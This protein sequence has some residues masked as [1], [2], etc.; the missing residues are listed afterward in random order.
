MNVF[1]YGT[2]LV[3]KIWN[4]VTRCPDLISTPGELAGFSV[5]KVRHGE[6]PGIVES[7]DSA[8]K[9]PGKVFFDVPEIALRRLDAYE[10]AYYERRSLVIRTETSGEVTAEAYCIPS[11]KA[12][13][14]LSGV[15]WTIEQFEKESL[16]R[17]WERTFG[18]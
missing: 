2:L 17:F 12:P 3:P 8:E 1:V 10:D 9:V 18:R 13:V 11:E 15:T 16:D 7:T 6:Y 5:Y 14:L 4:A